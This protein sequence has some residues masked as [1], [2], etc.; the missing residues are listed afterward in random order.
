MK[1]QDTDRWKATLE[2]DGTLALLDYPDQMAILREDPSLIKIGIQELLRFDSRLVS[3]RR[4]RIPGMSMVIGLSPTKASMIA[5]IPTGSTS[6]S[7]WFRSCG[8][9]SGECGPTMG[10]SSSSTRQCKPARRWVSRSSFDKTAMV[11]LAA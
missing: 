8:S 2:E 6:T 4:N 7:F 5:S 9:G 10:L 3:A 1:E 11:N